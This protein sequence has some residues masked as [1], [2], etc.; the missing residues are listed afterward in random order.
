MKINANAIAGLLIILASVCFAQ[1][2]DLYVSISL[3]VSEH[4]RDSNS[5]KTSF[6]ITGRKVIYDETYSGHRS[7]SRSPIHQEYE[8]TR[9]EIDNLKQLIQQR[10]LLRSRSF[11]TPLPDAPYTS[12]ELTE[13]IQWQG[14][15]VLIKVLGSPQA[16][17]AAEPKNRRA[18]EDANALLEYVRETVKK[19]GE[20]Q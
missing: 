20:A 3:V 6:V 11:T 2:N 8:F 17:A 15:R 4:S 5:T 14:A 19:K 1:P 9:Q 16:L 13:V 18:Y 12:Y 7:N 10:Q